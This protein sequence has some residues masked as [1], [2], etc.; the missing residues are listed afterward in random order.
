MRKVLLSDREI[1]EVVE[2]HRAEIDYLM[3]CYETQL[4][5]AN[6]EP[7]YKF[8]DRQT[9]QDWLDIANYNLNQANL[10]KGRIKEILGED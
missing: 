2:Y 6:T 9:K 7:L 5:I 8:G 4:K 3:S 1:L 10:R